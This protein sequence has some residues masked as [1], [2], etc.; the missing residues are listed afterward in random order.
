MR[1]ALRLMLGSLLLL[2]LSS[3]ALAQPCVVPD[4][5]G[6]TVHLPPPGCGYLSPNDVHEIIDGLPP[7][8]TIELDPIHSQF[9]NVTTIPGGPLGGNTEEFDSSLQLQLTGTGE[10][11]G[12]SRL[13]SIQVH[14]ITATAPRT[15]GDAVQ[16]FDT[17][18]MQLQGQL[19]GDPDFDQLTIVGG[20]NLVGPSPGQTTLTRLGPPGS[21]FVV[22]SFFDIEYRIDFQG[23]PGSILEGLSGSTTSSIQMSLPQ[24]TTNIVP[25]GRP[26]GLVLTAALLLVAGGLWIRRR[27]LA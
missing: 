26:W 15:P 25:A 23:A 1:T 13:L 17:E 7:G 5:G 18:M 10:L 22:D 4:N 2:S 6:G 24:V 8:T 21:D 16:T 11:A 27:V 3:M 14:C 19:F 12:F 20:T 9:F